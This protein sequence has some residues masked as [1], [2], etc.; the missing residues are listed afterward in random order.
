M[1]K[2]Q[3]TK[4]HY[5]HIQYGDKLLKVIQD[6]ILIEDDNYTEYPYFMA[7]AI[8]EMDNDYRIIF[9]THMNENKNKWVITDH[10]VIPDIC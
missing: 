6:P 8:D 7:Q 2:Y 5:G 4:I 10:Y 1:K 3:E 9:I